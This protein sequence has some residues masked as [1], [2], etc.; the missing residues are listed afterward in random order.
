MVAQVLVSLAR[1]FSLVRALASAFLYRVSRFSPCNTLIFVLPP[2]Q[3]CL[4]RSNALELA[5]V[6]SQIAWVKTPM[7]PPSENQDDLI[8]LPGEQSTTYGSI[9]TI[10]D[11]P[12]NDWK[13][14]PNC[15][16]L[17]STTPFRISDGRYPMVVQ[18]PDSVNEISKSPTESLQ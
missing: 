1:A 17:S 10:Y 15:E 11:S 9:W 8:V 12:G 3:G 4:Q 2:T 13:L 6:Q 14:P 5:V 16:Y 18:I 7:V